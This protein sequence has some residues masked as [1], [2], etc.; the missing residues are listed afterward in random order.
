[1]SSTWDRCCGRSS[2]VGICIF[3]M[4]WCIFAKDW[5]MQV[6]SRLDVRYLSYLGQPQGCNLWSYIGRT[7]GTATA[8]FPLFILA[9]NP[10]CFLYLK[11]S[12]KM[13]TV[14]VIQPCKL[15]NNALWEQISVGGSIKHEV[16]SVVGGPCLSPKS[17]L[18]DEMVE[19]H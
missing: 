16:C 2:M 18:K 10:K 4:G 7:W 9:A 12:L 19:S 15:I 11:L 14:A 6:M 17:V 3:F 13:E 1:M 5:I 8:R